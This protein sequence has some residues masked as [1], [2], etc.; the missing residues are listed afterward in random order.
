[1]TNNTQFNNSCHVIKNFVLQQLQYK[2]FN[3]TVLADEN[4]TNV[5]VYNVFSL[6]P[7]NKESTCGIHV[8]R[9]LDTANSTE[10]IYQISNRSHKQ[11]QSF[12]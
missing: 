3:L 9:T 6:S 12:S 5:D 4:L 10:A 11:L 8:N 1:M 2:I 7:V